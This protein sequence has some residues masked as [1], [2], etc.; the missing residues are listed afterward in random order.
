MDFKE[1]ILTAMNHEEPDQVP[2]MGLIIDPATI[3]QVLEKKPVDFVSMMRK[4]VLR[5]II[6]A[7]MNTNWFWNRFYSSTTAGALKSAAKL[8]FDANWTIYTLM[9]LN[10]DAQSELGVA[11]HDAYGRV[12]QISADSRGNMAVNYSRALIE[13]EDQWEAWVDKKAPLFETMIKNTAA[14]HRKLVA[15]YGDRVYPMGYAAPGIF[16]NSWQPMGF[17][18]FTRLIYQRPEFVKRVIDFQTDLY[19]RNLDAVMQSGV[20]VVLGGDDLGQKTGPMMRPELIEK[21]YG[22]SYRRVADYVHQRKRKFIFHSCGN[23]YQLLDKFIEWGFDGIITWSPPRGWTW[24]RYGS[25]WDT[26]WS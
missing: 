13:T 14:F 1:R 7:L 21:L 18:N 10:K 15:R 20:E 19:I 25:R 8:G 12:W 16:E 17:V 3:N 5:T 4:P 24:A 23:I 11:W 22:E 6:R 2:V 26:S 9:K